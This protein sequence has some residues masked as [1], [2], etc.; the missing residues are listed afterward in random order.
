MGGKLNLQ[1][2]LQIMTGLTTKLLDAVEANGASDFANIQR[3]GPRGLA[4]VGI[5]GE[6]EVTFQ[7]RSRVDAPWVDVVSF[8]ESSEIKASAIELFPQMRA[9]VSNYVNGEVSAWVVE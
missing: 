4:Q 8:T 2:K 5:T 3:Q 6:A 9:V 1:R 7:G